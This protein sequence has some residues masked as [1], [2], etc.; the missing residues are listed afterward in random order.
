MGLREDCRNQLKKCHDE[1]GFKS[2]RFYGLFDD[3]MCIQSKIIIYGFCC[4][5]G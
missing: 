4:V 2:V 1:L 5:T 3:C